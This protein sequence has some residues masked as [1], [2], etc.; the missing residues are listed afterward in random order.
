MRVIY[1]TIVLVGLLGMGILLDNTIWMF[2]AYLALILFMIVAIAIVLR[3]FMK[4][5]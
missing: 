1:A 3:R 2:V 5:R 4:T